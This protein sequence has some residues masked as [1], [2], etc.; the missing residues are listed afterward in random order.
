MRNRVKPTVATSADAMAAK[1]RFAVASQAY[2]ALTAAQ[3]LAWTNWAQSNP[4]VDRLGMKQ[5]LAANAAYIQL[6]TLLA[7]AGDSAI[8]LPPLETAPEPLTSCSVVMDIGVG[9]CSITFAATPLD[10]D[11]R[12]IVRACVVQSAGIQYIA[13]RLRITEISAKAQATGLDPQTAIETKF[14]SLQVGDIVH[15]QLSVMDSATGL[16]STPL[17]C[18]VAVT[19]T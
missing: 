2:Q 9:G 17:R 3:K 5:V 13:D 18:S 6:N 4:I 10:A 15:L 14:G 19:S 7:Q 8:S 12:L 16:Q 11:D 1:N